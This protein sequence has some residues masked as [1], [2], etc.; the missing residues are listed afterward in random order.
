MAKAVGID[1]GTTNSV[2]AVME[3]G[4]PTVL[5]NTEGN[6]TTPSVV[7]F[8]DGNRMVGQVAKRPSGA[9]RAKHFVR[10]EAL[11]R[12]HLGRGQRGSRAQP[13][14]SGQGRRWRYSFCRQ[15]T[16]ST[17]PKRSARWCCKSWSKTPAATLGEKITKAVIT[18]PAYFNNSQRE[19][20]Q[21]AGRR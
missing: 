4:E 11:H 6:R 8:K 18:V 12:A 19:A 17:P 3:G 9:E 13:L 5:V 14:R 21:N 20:T 10:G 15:V 16:K 2:I 1:L 7:A